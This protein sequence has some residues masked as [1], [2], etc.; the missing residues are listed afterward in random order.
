MMRDMKDRILISVMV[1]VYYFLL[2]IIFMG[3]F[4]WVLVVLN[5]LWEEI[6]LVI[7]ILVVLLFVGRRLMIGV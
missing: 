3:M 2:V 7:S 1:R 6:E 5:D 4:L